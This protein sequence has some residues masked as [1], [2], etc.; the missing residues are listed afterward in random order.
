MVW[1]NFPNQDSERIEMRPT[2]AERRRFFQR[3]REH[4]SS[5]LAGKLEEFDTTR[6]RAAVLGYLQLQVQA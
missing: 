5:D 6:A 1:S 3:R 4:S 2:S